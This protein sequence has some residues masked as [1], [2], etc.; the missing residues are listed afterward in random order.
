[1]NPLAKLLAAPSC[2][3]SR[4]GRLLLTC[5]L[6]AALAGLSGCTDPKVTFD[7]FVER[8]DEIQAQKPPTACPDAYSPLAPGAGDGQYLIV[9]SATQAPDTPILFVGEVTTPAIG[10]DVGIGF[11]ITPLD[12]TDRTT[13]VGDAQTFEPTVIDGSGKLEYTLNGLKVPAK[14]NTVAPIDVEAN[15]VLAGNV[16]GDGSFV[17][18]DV[19]GAVITPKVS[20]DGSTFTFMRVEEEGKYPDP[21][22]NCA[23]DAAAPL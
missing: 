18:G 15:V 14:A 3:P 8:Y 16:C 7:A 11:T 13:K 21:V 19:T 10:A 5:S 9:L 23:E 6:G 12:K 17:C 1:M 2:I 20:L 4:A 22:V